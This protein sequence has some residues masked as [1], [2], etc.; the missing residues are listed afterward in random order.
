MSNGP[1]ADLMNSVVFISAKNDDEEFVERGTAFF[2][3]V[4]NG[5][6]GKAFL[7]LVTA[8]HVVTRQD[9]RLY[10]TVYVRT[11]RRDGGF[12]ICDLN[13]KSA[14]KY[15]H[16]DESVDLVGIPL[17]GSMNEYDFSVISSDMIM[18]RERMS[19]FGVSVGDEVFFIGLFL[20]YYGKSR[21]YPIT[22]YGKISMIPG[23]RIPWK[24]VMSE[25]F[26]IESQ[27]F[28]GNSGSPVFA[29]FGPTRAVGGVID[30]STKIGLIGVLKG[31]FVENVM[32]PHIQQPTVCVNEEE[33]APEQAQPPTEI[34]LTPRV[35]PELVA[36]P[37][38][39]PEV[40]RVNF[41]VSAVVPGYRLYDVLFC[42][43]AR[44]QR[45]SGSG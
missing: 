17:S 18:T 35:S 7:H 27:S 34:G 10:D 3:G 43:A 1:I 4:P 24:G 8:K 9:G 29:L 44:A 28:G 37:D 16:D 22:R 20:P 13:L 14:S 31:S 45:Q 41:G 11:N 21:N 38:E 26:L 30:M 5:D 36:Q 40:L 32:S 23:E 25:L 39:P 19:D 2:V 12:E 6:D 42:A 15:F 33:S